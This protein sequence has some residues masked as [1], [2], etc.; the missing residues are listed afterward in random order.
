MSNRLFSFVGGDTGFWRVTTMEA[1]TGEPLPAISRLDVSS[2]TYSPSTNGSTWCL[3]GIISHEHY[4]DREERTE[5]VA[6]QL[7]LGRL[8]ATRAALIPI[9]KNP[10]WWVLTQNERMSIYIID[11]NWRWSM[12]K[13]LSFDIG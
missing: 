10:D 7:P 6:K 4:V 5:I 13:I 12:N 1:V 9:R 11:C 8:E 2:A 3:R